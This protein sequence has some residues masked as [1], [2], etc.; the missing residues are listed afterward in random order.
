MTPY[1][2]TSI[3]GQKKN[4]MTSG[5]VISEVKQVMISPGKKVA[6]KFMRLRLR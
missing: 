2:L 5:F 1:W 6:A 4:P 3:S